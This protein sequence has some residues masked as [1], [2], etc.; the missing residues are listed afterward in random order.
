VVA[1][2][3]HPTSTLV[4]AQTVVNDY[5]FREIHDVVRAD[6]DSSHNDSKWPTIW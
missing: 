6:Y 3:P 5:L 4:V 2:L 1:T